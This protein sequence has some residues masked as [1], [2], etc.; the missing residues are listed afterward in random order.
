MEQCSVM[1]SGKINQEFSYETGGM[2]LEV[3]EE[4]RYLEVIM[5]RSAKLSRQRQRRIV[6]L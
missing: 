6:K 3:S 5:L 2:V 1:H 4:E